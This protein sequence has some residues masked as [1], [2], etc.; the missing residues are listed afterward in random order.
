MNKR[1]EKVYNRMPCAIDIPLSIQLSAILIG[2]LG[3]VAGIIQIFYIG[4]GM[5]AFVGFV[6]AIY[7]IIF[8]LTLISVEIYVLPFF[9]Y[10]G[11]LLKLWG[12][13]LMY[14]FVGGLLF[15]NYGLGLACAIF[16][17]IM[18]IIFGIIGIFFPVGAPP[19]AQR[20]ARPDVAVSSSEIYE[21]QA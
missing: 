8:C 5:D 4:S 7:A 15:W 10:F 18:A 9:K 17:W 12:K 6:R 19:L 1:P 2:V 21:G 3:V 16:Y 11:F 20:A 14:V 13:G